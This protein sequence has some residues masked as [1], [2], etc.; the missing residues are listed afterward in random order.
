MTALVNFVEERE[1]TPDAREPRLSRR[2]EVKTTEADQALVGAINTTRPSRVRRCCRHRR[3][4]RRAHC[5]RW[6]S[7]PLVATTRV[8]VRFLPC[9]N[10]T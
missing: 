10:S 3:H 2:V 4:R 7:L 6:S 5:P 8:G 1:S 9:G